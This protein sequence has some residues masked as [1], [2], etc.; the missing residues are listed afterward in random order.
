M[1]SVSAMQIYIYAT[2]VSVFFHHGVTVR[3]QTTFK[4]LQ[5]SVNHIEDKRIRICEVDIS[6]QNYILASIEIPDIQSKQLSNKTFCAG[7]KLP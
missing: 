5:L 6:I 4:A 1:V 7:I 2:G 3:F